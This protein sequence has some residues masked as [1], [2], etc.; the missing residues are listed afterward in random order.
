[1]SDTGEVDIYS[2]RATNAQSARTLAP[3]AMGWQT[4]ILLYGIYLVLHSQYVR[5]PSYARIRWQVKT[6]LWAVCFFLTVYTGLMF[7]ELTFWVVN[8]EHRTYGE[9]LTGF[10]FESI[11]PLFAGLVAAPVQALLT[12]RTA[13]L[14]RNKVLRWSFFIWTS[15][16]IALGFISAIL[17]CTVN[18]YYFST[19][20]QYINGLTWSRTM[21]M[22]LWA[23]ASTDILI[24][25][26]LGLTIRER[27]PGFDSSTH[28]V[29]KF[30]FSAL[31]T[32][33][34]TA[35]FA[36]IGATL[37]AIYGD[38]SAW[39]GVPYAFWAQ[40]PACY[41]VS[42]YTTL[43]SRRHVEEYIDSSVPLPGAAEHDLSLPPVPRRTASRG[44]DT[45]FGEEQSRREKGAGWS[46][47][48]RRTSDGSTEK[49]E[50]RWLTRSGTP[51]IV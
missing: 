43:S 11:P 36:V 38:N 12:L 33:S 32:A 19:G 41:G 14:L 1:M 10:E 46:E 21:A 40:L 34:Y 13:S 31:Q 3:C 4:A 51:D 42:L 48:A 50:E 9:V 25:I 8:S 18:V 47:V 6:V 20:G 27:V 28:G 39:G 37:F 23:N 2:L 17:A 5:S 26:L 22:L 15:L 35:V 49:A 44:G 45:N 7:T 29:G 24:T 16:A 30:V